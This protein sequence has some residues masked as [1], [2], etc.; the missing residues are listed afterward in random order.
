MNPEV[1]KILLSA[2]GIYTAI[3]LLFALAFVLWGVGRIDL[4]ARRA[5][6]GFRLTILPATVALWPVLAHRWLRRLQPPEERNDHR[7][8]AGRDDSR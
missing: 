6:L 3:G 7:L 2:T 5:T 1:A 4:R 8:A